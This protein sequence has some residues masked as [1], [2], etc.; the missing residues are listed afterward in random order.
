VCGPGQD[1]ESEYAAVIS[2]FI[3]ACLLGEPAVIY[4]DGLQ[5]RDFTFIDDVVEAN[6]LASRLP[7]SAYGSPLQHRG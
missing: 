7:A 6:I 1:P 5:S 2:R 4:G 3:V